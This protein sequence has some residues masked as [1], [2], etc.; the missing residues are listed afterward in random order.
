MESL[1]TSIIVK[2]ETRKRLQER[3]LE[4][5]LKNVDEVI[6]QSLELSGSKTLGKV[7]KIKEGKKK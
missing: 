1:R 7:E 2:P 5:D 4:W 3:K 6:N